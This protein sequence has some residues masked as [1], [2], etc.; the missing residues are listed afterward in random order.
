M[1][2]ELEYRGIRYVVGPQQG[3]IRRWAIYPDGAPKG[4]TASGVARTTRARGAFKEAVNNACAA[5]DEWLGRGADP[6]GCD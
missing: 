3:E 2:Q 6:V 5:I 4:G 1:E